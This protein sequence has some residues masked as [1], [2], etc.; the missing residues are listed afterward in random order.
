LISTFHSKSV[1]RQVEY[2]QK[3]TFRA[4]LRW[5]KA[6]KV[7]KLEN[8]AIIRIFLFLKGLVGDII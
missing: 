6:K 3:G 1:T 7:R 8:L 5:S 2:F 4:S